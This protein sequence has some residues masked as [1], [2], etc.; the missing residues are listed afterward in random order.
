[1]NDPSKQPGMISWVDL[2]VGDAQRVRDFYEKVAGWTSAAVSMGD[3][4]DHCMNA[5]NGQTVAGICHARGDNSG[6]PAQWLVYINVADLDQ[7]IKACEQEG[8]KV[9]HGPRSIG[10]GRC[11]VIE[12]PAGACAALY[13]QPSE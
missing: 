2:T 6:L 10:G 11:A 1:M 4:D 3:Y 8:G 13:Q 9:L 5:S 7:S 12:D